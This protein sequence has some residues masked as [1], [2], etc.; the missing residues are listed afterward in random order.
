MGQITRFVAGANTY[1]FP[2]THGDQDYHDNFKEILTRSSRIAG[3]DGGLDEYGSG[4]APGAVGSIQFGIVLESA[5]REGMQVLRDGLATIREWGVG[6]LYF[7]PTDSL[8]SPRWCICRAK[9]AD[10]KEKRHMHTDLFQPVPMAFEA[11]EP[12]WMTAGNQNLW[13]STYNWNSAINWDGTGL[14]TITGSGSLIVTNNGN[15]FT[16][17]RFVAKV[18][19]AQAFNQLIVRRTVNGGVIDQWVINYPFVQNDVIEV[20]PRKQW[21]LVNGHDRFS[22]FE[23]RHPDWLRLLPGANTITVTTEQASAAL[24][25]VIRYYERYV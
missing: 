14:T 4:R 24:D 25:T 5:T 23:F 15:A 21:V 20:D 17:G 8:L 16:T 13:D 12:F 11:S 1:T 9:N 3:A 2:T 22:A 19:G 7:Q 6:Q 18:T 10:V